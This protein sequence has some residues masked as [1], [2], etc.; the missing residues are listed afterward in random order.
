M[1]LLASERS[2]LESACW[3]AGWLA[4]WLPL[5][6][7]RRVNHP[8][9][10]LRLNGRQADGAMKSLTRRQSPYQARKISLPSSE[11]REPAS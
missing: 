4:D 7:V 1:H 2:R 11:Q 8:P 3:L 9:L 10:G 5:L 6:L